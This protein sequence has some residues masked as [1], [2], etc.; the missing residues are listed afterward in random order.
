MEHD[1]HVPFLLAAGAA[2]DQSSRRLDVVEAGPGF[3]AYAWDGDMHA[4]CITPLA[5]VATHAAQGHHMQ[6]FESF[7]EQAS[8]MP[9]RRSA[10]ACT[11][12]ALNAAVHPNTQPDSLHDAVTRLLTIAAVNDPAAAHIVLQS[13]VQVA[14]TPSAAS[15]T[16]VIAQC[17]LKAAADLAAE[18]ARL[19]ARQ[20]ML[21]HV[22]DAQQQAGVVEEVSQSFGLM[23]TASAEAAAD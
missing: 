1:E 13:F 14:P 15:A 19:P 6:V 17:W 4:G 8:T 10:T 20:L 16:G 9:A 5:A 7:L 12:A 18:Q 22:A 23:Y 21:V 3:Q 11:D 2:V